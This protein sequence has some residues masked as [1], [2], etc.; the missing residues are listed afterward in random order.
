MFEHIA[1]FE[2]LGAGPS[3]SPRRVEVGIRVRY[4]DVNGIRTRY[5]EAGADQQGPPLLLVHGGGAAADTWFRNLDALGEVQQVLAPDLLGHGFTDLPDLPPDRFPQE[6][7]ADHVAAFTQALGL[8]RFALMG[9]SFGGLIAALLYLADPRRV[10]RL[11]LVASSSVFEEPLRHQNA[12]G[13]AQQNQ[14]PALL[15]PTPENIRRRNVGSNYDS[16]D[17]FEEIVPI[18]MSALGLPGR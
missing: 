6:V 12:V 10:T 13:G 2:R 5:Y 16:S 18:Q 8:K 15:D 9:H 11:V 14:L 3:P 7:E 1:I 4:V 17:P